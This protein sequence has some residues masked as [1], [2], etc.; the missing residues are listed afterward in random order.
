MELFPDIIGFLILRDDLLNGNHL[1]GGR[2]VT[3]NLLNVKDENT[4]FVI[5]NKLPQ[6]VLGFLEL[7]TPEIT[8]QGRG[9]NILGPALAQNPRPFSDK[10]LPFAGYSN[11]QVF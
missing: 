3:D 1:I 11:T 9:I 4:A 2:F 10:Y 5:F 8:D 6:T 7:F